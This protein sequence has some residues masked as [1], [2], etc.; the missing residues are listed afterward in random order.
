MAE[1]QTKSY[2]MHKL[3]EIGVE[4]NSRHGQNFLIDLN[5]VELIARSAD[6]GPRD[7]VLEIGT[8]TGSL[9]ELM[10]PQASHVITVE[11]D[12]NLYELAS[13]RLL[14]FDNVTQLQVDALRNKGSFAPEVLEAVGDALR[15]TPDSRLKL[16]ANLPYNVATPILSNL[17]L[18]DYTPHSMVATIQKELADRIVAEPWSKDY[19]ALSI[20]MQSQA[21]TEIVRVM[22][23]KVFWPA[24]KVES[25]IVK[26]VVDPERRAAIP[27]LKYFQQI[28]RALFL[29]R[30]KFLRAN[31][32]SAMKRH[33]TKEQVDAVLDEMEFADDARTEQIDIATMQTFTEKL[34]QLAPDWTL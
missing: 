1:R 25:A 13:E 8:G 26:I 29:H 12:A 21:T 34:R 28:V 31:V 19:G 22:S 20:W 18:C 23:P 14:R 27:D 15:G 16:V 9:T 5:L 30:R 7:V 32:T 4:P 6:L 17:L 3:R 10:A 33:L 24:P 2:L 11:I